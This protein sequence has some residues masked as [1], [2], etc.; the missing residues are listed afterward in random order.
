[1]GERVNVL[2]SAYNGRKYIRE[3][4]DSVL[5]QQGVEPYIY[6][7]DDGSSDG[8]ADY[9]RSIYPEE[10]VTVMEGENLGHG[11]SF[12]ELTR[13]AEE[14]S[15]WAFCD[16]DDVWLPHKLKK[17]LE[18]MKTQDETKPLLFHSAYECRN[19]ALSQGL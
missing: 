6:V 8:T 5:E 9:V 19:K 12:Y 1:M 2:I 13:S 3:Q 10:R 17:A 18:W 7:R 15:Y 16:Q 14:G 4:I 11:G